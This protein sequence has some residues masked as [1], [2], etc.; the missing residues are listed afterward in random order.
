MAIFL[1]RDQRE[2]GKKKD[3]KEGRKESRKEGEIN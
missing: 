3:G 2:E 1:E